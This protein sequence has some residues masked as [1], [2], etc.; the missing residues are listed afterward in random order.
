[1]KQES[2]L[3]YNQDYDQINQDSC[4]YINQEISPRTLI[5]YKHG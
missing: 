5:H 1:M 2:W 3:N 4:G